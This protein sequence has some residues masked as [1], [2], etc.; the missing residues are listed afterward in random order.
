MVEKSSVQLKSSPKL[1]SAES[2]LRIKINAPDIAIH[3][4]AV[5]KSTVVIEVETSNK[6]QS[7]EDP[8]ISDGRGE[9]QLPRLILSTRSTRYLWHGVQ[10]PEAALGHSSFAALGNFLRV[11]ALVRVRAAAS[12]QH[13][14]DVGKVVS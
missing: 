2:F 4:S 6:N 11:S 9:Q 5:T 12:I 7:V 1:E 8:R 13:V 10:K 14:P 3:A